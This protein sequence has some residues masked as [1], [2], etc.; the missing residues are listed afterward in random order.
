MKLPEIT[1]EVAAVWVNV[2]ISTTREV[3]KDDKPTNADTTQRVVQYFYTNQSEHNRIVDKLDD[4]IFSGVPLV[5][6]ETYAAYTYDQ[7]MEK[8]GD[9]WVELDSPVTHQ[10]PECVIKTRTTAEITNIDAT[11]YAPI[12][13]FLH[14]GFRRLP[15]GLSGIYAVYRGKQVYKRLCGLL[16]GYYY[17]GHKISRFGGVEH[18]LINPTGDDDRIILNSTFVNGDNYAS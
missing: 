18:V 12:P 4:V 13:K 17:V 8:R 7:T 2:N 10:S 5:H 14:N 1:D 16:G 6:V 15:D 11:T 9:K 3:F